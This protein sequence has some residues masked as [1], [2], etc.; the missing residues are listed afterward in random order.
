[1]YDITDTNSFD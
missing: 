1:M